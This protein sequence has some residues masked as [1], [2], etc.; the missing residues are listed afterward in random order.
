M[1]RAQR[2]KLAEL[3]NSR[4]VAARL[5]DT[6]LAERYF[7]QAAEIDLEDSIGNVAGGVHAGALGGLYALAYA[8]IASTERT[9]RPTAAIGELGWSHEPQHRDRCRMTQPSPPGAPSPV[10]LTTRP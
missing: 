6:A 4:A 3:G 9:C 7:R 10:R 1:E 8:W 5:G 2:L